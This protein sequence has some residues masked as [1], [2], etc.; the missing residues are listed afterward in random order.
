MGHSHR[1]P[2]Q[3]LAHLPDTGVFP[4]V[5]QLQCRMAQDHFPLLPVRGSCRD[6]AI[7]Q[8]GYHLPENP[9]ISFC[10]PA[11]HDTIAAGLFQN[12]FCFFRAVHIP[13]ADHWNL[14]CILHLCDDI[15]VCLSAVVLGSRPSVHRHRC[16]TTGF[17]DLRD[18]HGID[19]VIVEAF[20][21]LHCHRLIDGFYQ[22]GQN[23]LHQLR[24]LH[25]RG[26]F[27][28]VH[29]LRHRAAH[30]Q[31][32]YGKRTFLDPFCHLRKDLGI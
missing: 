10:R 18:L 26:A 31:I 11:D 14:H 8:I 3:V 20:S 22:C 23:L 24:I 13:V 28:V 30:I 12:G 29:D 25:Q 2:G 17:R 21:D 4:L 27:A 7:F 32:Q 1:I 6:R 15:P 5:F 19:M 9:G 16:H